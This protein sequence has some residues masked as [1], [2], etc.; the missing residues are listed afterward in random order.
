[1]GYKVKEKLH[2]G[3]NEEKRLNIADI[4]GY[5]YVEMHSLNKENLNETVKRTKSA[6]P[7]LL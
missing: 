4:E 6:Q 3:V 1:L 5:C 7:E 2:L